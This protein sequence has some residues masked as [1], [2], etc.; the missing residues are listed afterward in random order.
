MTQDRN[1]PVLAHEAASYRGLTASSAGVNLG[2]IF[3]EALCW[4]DRGAADAMY[5]YR[6]R[7]RHQRCLP[8]AAV[9]RPSFR[10]SGQQGRFVGKIEISGR[11]I[12][13]ALT[14]AR[15]SDAYGI[16]FRLLLP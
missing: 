2:D 7:Q 9:H 4:H 12:E 14:G 5:S 10:W 11:E 3:D 8:T 1:F 16:G 15:R 6:A 13:L